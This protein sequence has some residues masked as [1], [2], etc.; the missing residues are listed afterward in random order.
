MRQRR[1]QRVDQPR[2]R[3]AGGTRDI[4][5][6]D[7]DVRF[8]VVRHGQNPRGEGY[9]ERWLHVQ[10]RVKFRWLGFGG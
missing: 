6:L 10:V 4:H 2:G 3:D 9:H 5:H 7:V 8:Q 1:G